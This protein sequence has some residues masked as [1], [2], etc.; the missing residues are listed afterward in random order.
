MLRRQSLARQVF[1]F[2]LSGAQSAGR[3]GVYAAAV[4]QRTELLA[5][6][7]IQPAQQADGS[8]PVKSFRRTD[9][10]GRSRGRDRAGVKA[11]RAAL[12]ASRIAPLPPRRPSGV[13]QGAWLQPGHV[14]GAIACPLAA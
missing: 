8:L 6:G 14:H 7:L 13:A 2:W 3:V 5:L 10:R 11:A 4:G 1:G 12:W 9:G